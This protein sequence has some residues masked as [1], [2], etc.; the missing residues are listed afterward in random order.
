[1]TS[2]SSRVLRM[3]AVLVALHVLACGAGP[4]AP[5]P[6]RVEAFTGAF[7]PDHVYDLDVAGPGVVNASLVWTADPQ[8]PSLQGHV[9]VL[10]VDGLYTEHELATA[11]TARPPATV[12]VNVTTKTCRI[13]VECRNCGGSFPPLPFSLTVTHP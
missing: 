11:L 3:G 10:F 8:Q 4:T 5:E 13:R 6:Q 7:P 12:A 2:V 9:T 1:M